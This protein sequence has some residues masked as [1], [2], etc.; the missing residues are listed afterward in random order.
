V[1]FLHRE[2]KKKVAGM[3]D[4]LEEVK[5]RCP[6]IKRAF[7]DKTGEIIAWEVDKEAYL[8]FLKVRQ[9]KPKKEKI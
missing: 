6:L 3:T 8:K 5:V 4:D 9:E 1:G 7:K 2:D